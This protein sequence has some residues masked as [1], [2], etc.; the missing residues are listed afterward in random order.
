MAEAFLNHFAG[1]IFE[2]ES[3]GLEAGKLNPL[4]VE[5]MSEI[6]MDISLNKTKGVF[7]FFKAGK[8]Y[9]TIITVCDES[10][11]ERCPVFP[12]LV[13]RLHWS[14][15]DPSSFTGTR[16]ERK[17][18]TRQVR[19]QIKEKIKEFVERERAD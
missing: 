6:D 14:F 9:H 18:K 16:Q 4:V 17:N 7:E 19:D 10:N 12:G 2:A 15:P 1:D 8:K 3:A 11:A 5:V 13:E